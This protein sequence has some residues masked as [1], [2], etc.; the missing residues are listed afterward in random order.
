VTRTLT[1]VGMLV[2]LVLSGC[3][4]PVDG[5]A[6]T[7]GAV[8]QPETRRGPVSLEG[9]EPALVRPDELALDVPSCHGAPEITQLIE[10]PDA[11]RLEVVTT[12]ILRGASD[13]CLDGLA[14]ELE[15]PLGDREVV[16]LVSGTTLAVVD[17]TEVLEC[18][19]LGFPLEPTFHTPEEAL[20]DVLGGQLPSGVVPDRVE[21]YV[22]EDREGQVFF[23]HI[24]DDHHVLYTWGVAQDDDGRWGVV[25]LGGC[26]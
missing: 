18:A 25:S 7:P 11:V 9:S 17:Q 6:G 12:Q 24:V 2:A 8:E 26:F 10:D 1:L 16:D 23:D 13:D 14:V 5:P 21:D 22:R 3:G 4:A 15:Q 20:A 19:D